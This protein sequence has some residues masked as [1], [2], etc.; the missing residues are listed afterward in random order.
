L[1]IAAR[2]ISRGKLFL[3]ANDKYAELTQT[4]LSSIVGATTLAINP[5]QHIDNVGR[6]FATFDQGGRVDDHKIVLGDRF[7]IVSV[8]PFYRAG[9][10]RPSAISVTLQ[11]ITERKN[12][13][14]ALMA[15]N[16]ELSLAKQEIERLAY[17]DAVTGI[18][19]HQHLC[20]DMR[21]SYLNNL[22]DIG[23]TTLRSNHIQFIKM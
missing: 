2:L 13:E 10:N 18:E 4:L 3:A 15:A 8:S 7:P 22:L 12:A 14:T 23:T 16:R 20:A 9:E 17:V 11:N 21:N 5:K 6:D 1:P 19:C